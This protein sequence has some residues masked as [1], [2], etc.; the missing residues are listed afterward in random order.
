[1]NVL[2]LYHFKKRIALVDEITTKQ[3]IITALKALGI[4]LFFMFAPLVGLINLLIVVILYKSLWATIVGFILVYCIVMCFW[5]TDRLFRKYN[6]FSVLEQHKDDFLLFYNMLAVAIGFV[7]II[8]ILF[9]V[10]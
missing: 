8:V 3:Y 1:M 4:T 2:K 6:E 9:E 7:A 10:M 5:N